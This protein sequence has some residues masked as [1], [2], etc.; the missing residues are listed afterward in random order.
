MKTS[1]SFGVHF[2]IKKEKAKDGTTNV[3]VSVTRL[4]QIGMNRLIG[5]ISEDFDIY[6]LIGESMKHFFTNV[7][8]QCFA[9]WYLASAIGT[10]SI[11]RMSQTRRC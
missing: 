8:E 7:L 10:S 4:H 6:G 1:Q 11:V 5:E 9:N 2:T 3:Y